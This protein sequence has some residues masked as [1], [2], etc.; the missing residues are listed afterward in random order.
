MRNLNEH[1]ITAAVV[2]RF[3]N[4]PDPRL[5]EVMT[6]LVKHLHAF[7]RD[8]RLSFTEWQ[9]AVD[10][11][12][13]TG[14]ICTDTRQEF[15]LL[16]DTLGLSMLVDA[17]DH[18]ETSGVTESTVLGPFYVTDVPE[19]PLGANVSGGL[20]GDPLFVE[21]T[22]STADGRR[23]AGAVVDT[24]HSDADGFYDVQLSNLSGAASRG[25]FRTDAR[26]QFHFWSIMPRFYP[27]PDDGPVGQMLEATKRH[28]FRPA[29]VHFLISAPGYE[30]LVTH[31]FASDSPYL[32]SDAVFGVKDALIREFTHEPAGV[33]PDG[34]AMAQSWRRLSY[35]FGLKRTTGRTT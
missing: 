12:T 16:S 20:R 4:T 25:R 22:V 6:S 10:F 21:G 3:A 34:T 5:K 2:D 23:I 17:I 19:F 11:L 7:A 29:H 9:Q 30:T 14:Q 32:D 24:W 15:V 35:D 33:A 31:V 8:V 18:P 26:G 13:R 27:I 1:T 28:P